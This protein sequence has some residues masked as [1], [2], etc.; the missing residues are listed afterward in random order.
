M[1]I[2]VSK[3]AAI[4]TL[5]LAVVFA[6]CSGAFLDPGVI[7]V[8]GLG[9]TGLGGGSGGR[10]PTES[11]YTFGNLDQLEGSVTAVTITANS[12]KSP[13]AV[14]NIRYDNST[15]IPQ[16]VGYY[17]VTFDVEKALGWDAAEG[18]N[19]GMLNVRTAYT[20][21][22]DINGG[23][24]T[25]PAS[26]T[27]GYNTSI[28]LPGGTGFSRTD[29][30]FIGWNT[31]AA[32]TGANHSA[33]A[34]YTVNGNATLYAK[35]SSNA[36]GTEGNP[37][38]LTADIWANGEITTSTD[39]REVWYSFNVTEG[40]TYYVWWNDSNSG[41]G[42]KTLDVR[43]SA[44]YSNG[45]SIFT[46]EDSA[47]TSSRSITAD[48]TGTVK[49]RVQPWSGGN[50]GTFAIVYSMSPGKPISHTVTYNIN[51]GIGTTP[52]SQIVTYEGASITL[53]DGTGFSRTDYVF[54]GWNTNSSGTGTNYSA[55][56]SYTV[57]NDIILYAKWLSSLP[58][59]E[60]NPFQL[61]DRKWTNGEIT[62]ST[63]NREVWYSFNV[64][65]GARYY[66]WWND[67]YSGNTTKTLDVRVSASYSN[68]SSIFTGVDAAW[69]T[70]QEFNAASTG[71]VKLRV[72]PYNS[73]NTGTFAVVY[74]TTNSVIPP[75][76][77]TF[78]INGGIG[79][80]PTP[81]YPSSG[82][83]IAL[84]DGSGFSKS[85]YAFGG[86][87]TNESGTGTNYNGGAAYPNV[88]GDITFYAK[89][90]P[91]GSEGNPFPLT[92]EIWLNGEITA[93]TLNGEVWYSFDVT[94][95]DYYI[96]WNDSGTNG[97]DGTKTLDVVVSAYYSNGSTIFTNEDTA[98]IS[99]KMFFSSFSNS[100][101]KLKVIPKSAGNT[102]TF[103]IV[104]SKEST[105]WP[106]E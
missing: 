82:V 16:D 14:K 103:A 63:L 86:W 18:L 50:T 90:N 3:T 59:A 44:S 91:S 69:S 75:Y 35:W 53:P 97:G 27:V 68:G 96:W 76:T 47:W 72:Q 34:S 89:W 41:N 26:R 9:G 7:E 56:S 24:G 73:S 98:W 25:T 101:V 13:G 79:T 55:G 4:L 31:N 38:L 19:A 22:F 78:D 5:L 104:Y 77:V 106:D 32:G 2:K 70:P 20:V 61:T 23:T 46:G 93:S 15:T 99:Y 88:T 43:V 30:E 51:S 21:N 6:S 17:T 66:V 84:P 8:I 60:G 102:G 85:G 100:T 92:E 94:Q 48:S 33:G 11:D 37:I 39:N 65:E 71:T 67:I 49:L 36:A 12:G 105:F 57:N 62:T 52:D 81:Q 58:G 1:K 95:T 80:P 42:T 87:N 45:S 64:T 28:T 29:Y 54:S 40:D 83:G 74:S 10:T